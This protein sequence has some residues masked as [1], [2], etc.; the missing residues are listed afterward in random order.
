MLLFSVIDVGVGE[1]QAAAANS[2]DELEVD[3]ENV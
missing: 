2:K 3:L 1:V